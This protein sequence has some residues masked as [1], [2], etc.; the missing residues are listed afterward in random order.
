MGVVSRKQN[1][2][3]AASRER[4]RYYHTYKKRDVCKMA[5]CVI[6]DVNGYLKAFNKHKNTCGIVPVFMG[7]KGKFLSTH[8]DLTTLGEQ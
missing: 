4:L 5:F 6:Y 8:L 7:T 3:A 1:S 2:E